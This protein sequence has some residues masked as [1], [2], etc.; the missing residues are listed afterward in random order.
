MD[1]SK[2][3]LM[4]DKTVEEAVING[5]MD[6][7]FDIIVF[8]RKDDDDLEELDSFTCDGFQIISNVKE[9]INK[10][11]DLEDLVI[12]N[13]FTKQLDSDEVKDLLFERMDET[14]LDVWE[15]IY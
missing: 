14:D 2:E 7:E 4:I 8:K 3:S 5:L 1:K 13:V 6:T 10:V 12:C 15:N 9:F 11:D